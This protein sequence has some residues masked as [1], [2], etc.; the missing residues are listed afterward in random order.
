MSL[1]F[2]FKLIFCEA[3]L[4]SQKSKLLYTFELW[5]DP[6]VA[7]QVLRKGAGNDMNPDIEHMHT[8]AF[9]T[10]QQYGR[11]ILFY[12]PVLSFKSLHKVS[13][14]DLLLN[15]DFSIEDAIRFF[16]L[17]E[18]RLEI[19][20]LWWK[21][22]ILEALA[23][24]RIDVTGRPGNAANVGDTSEWTH[25][26]YQTYKLITILL[27][28]RFPIVGGWIYYQPHQQIMTNEAWYVSSTKMPSVL[29]GQIT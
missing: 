23:M 10:F 3:F 29:W 1:H 9:N 18:K 22:S 4:R 24:S 7:H 11:R 28:A 20:M 2:S 26:T 25:V 5:F 16:T 15:S 17:W 19:G 6:E 8:I 12:D 13:F 14:K 27:E 21:D